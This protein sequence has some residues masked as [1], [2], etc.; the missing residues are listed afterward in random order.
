MQSESTVDRILASIK[1]TAGHRIRDLSIQCH[2]D[3]VKIRGKSKSFYG[4]Q[5]VNHA[6]KSLGLTLHLDNEIEVV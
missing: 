1:R 3:R 4:K 6:F 5:L 2:E